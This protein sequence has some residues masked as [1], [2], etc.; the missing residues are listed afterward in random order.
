[1]D[2]VCIPKIVHYCWF[3]NKE[4]PQKVKKCIESW[5]KHLIGYQFIEWNESNFDVYQNKYI[6]QAYNAKKFAFVSDVARLQALN[7]YGGIYLDT[8]VEVFKSFGDLLNHKC[9]LGFEEGNYVATSFMACVQSHPLIEEF[10]SEYMNASF[11][12]SDGSLNLKTNVGR[13]T[14]ILLKGGLDRND[15]Y[16]I[17]AN[18][19]AV[20]PKEYFSPYDY[21]NCVKDITK[22]SYCIHHFYVSWMP[23]QTRAKKILKFLFVKMFGRNNMKMIR[24]SF[25]D[26]KELIP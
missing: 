21:I 24:Q 11:L 7:Q 15:E 25:N 8:D 6:E 16:Q 17:L 5:R 14:A 23:W 26:K 4:K 20:Y 2:N 13:L 1:M 9:L 18:D 10:I 22:N 12:E 3:G 19:I